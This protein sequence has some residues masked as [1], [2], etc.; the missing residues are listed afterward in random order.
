[1]VL[2]ETRGLRLFSVI[3]GRIECQWRLGAEAH[4]SLTWE[5]ILT[6]EPS[7]PE[8]SLATSE[9][10]KSPAWKIR[11]RDAQACSFRWAASNPPSCFHTAKVTA[12]TL[13]ASVRRAMAG[14]LP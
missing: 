6:L 5:W 1:M 14:F 12:A 2:L 11:S 9:A 13:R 8:T 7:A 10:I 3:R 4:D